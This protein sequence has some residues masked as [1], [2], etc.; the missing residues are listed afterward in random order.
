MPLVQPGQPLGA[1]QVQLASL[2]V[3][4]P[5]SQPLPL[6]QPLGI[7]RNRLQP[8][9]LPRAQLALLGQQPG[10]PLVLQVSPQARAR[11]KV[12][13]LLGLQLGT[14]VKPQ[15]LR[16]L[17]LAQQLQL[18]LPLA[19]QLRVQQQLGPQT[20]PQT[21]PLHGLQAVRPIQLGQLPGLL[22]VQQ[23]SL[24]L[25]HGIRQPRGRQPGILTSQPLLLGQLP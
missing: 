21:G 1:L 8:L 12:Q 10:L 7:R 15:P 16:G 4:V 3:K 24:L 23:L 19:Q 2:Q 18:G 11:H 20:G 25:L 22:R 6:G 5:I 17:P 14:L 13:L 9:G